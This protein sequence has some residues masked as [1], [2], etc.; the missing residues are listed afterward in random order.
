MLQ[1]IYK[2]TP[3][4]VKSKKEDS[5]LHFPIELCLAR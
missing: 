3:K 1:A 5:G 2:V 4:T